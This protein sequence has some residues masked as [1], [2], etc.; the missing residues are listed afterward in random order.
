MALTYPIVAEL[1][2]GR[3]QLGAKE[4]LRIQKLIPSGLQRL[5]EEVSQDTQKRRFLLTD[6]F[7][8]TAT[9][10]ATGAIDLTSLINSSGLML[11]KIR[12]GAIYNG[13]DQRQLDYFSNS[14]FAEYSM[15]FANTYQTKFYRLTGRTLHAFR[16]DQTPITTDLNF[17]VPYTPTLSQMPENDLLTDL[18]D[19]LGEM[20]TSGGLQGG[21]T[22]ADEN[23]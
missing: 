22:R 16:G 20:V 23:T 7:T 5:A 12:Y 10:D 18:L 19:I 21:V 1:V 15:A 3:L 13:T 2:R 11:D 6:R 8:V 4:K 9:P 17:Q 14:Q